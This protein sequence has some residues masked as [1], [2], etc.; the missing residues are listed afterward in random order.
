MSHKGK[1]GPCFPC[2]GTGIFQDETCPT[3]KGQD[4][5]LAEI[6]RASRKPY[7]AQRRSRGNESAVSGFRWRDCYRA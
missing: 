6:V 2:D 5:A 4:V 3:C 7:A 1:E